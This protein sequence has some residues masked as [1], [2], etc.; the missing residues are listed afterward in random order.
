MIQVVRGWK[1]IGAKLEVLAH[2]SMETLV[3]PWKK[4]SK[5]VLQVVI[6]ETIVSLHISTIPQVDNTAR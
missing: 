2:N 3:T 6:I 4:R 5:N 1:D